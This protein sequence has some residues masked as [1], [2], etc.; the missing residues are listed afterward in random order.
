VAGPGVPIDPS[1]GPI[2]A[3][4]FDMDGLLID[5]EPLW[6]RVE[7]TI[8]ER[9]GVPLTE[10]RCVE[11]RGMVVS[12][13]TRHWYELD[14]WTGPSPEA[15]AEEIVEAMA[16]ELATGVVLKAGAVAALSSCRAHGLRLAIAS[17]SPARLI[18]VVVEAS[19]L[20]G[21]FSVLHS[22][23]EEKV[24]KPDPAVFLTTARHLGVA[25]GRCV[26]FEDSPAGVRAAIDA[27][28][29]CVA[30]PEDDGGRTPADRVVFSSADAVLHSL[31]EVND[32]LWARLS[33]GGS[34]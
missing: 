28:M 22:G 21:W 4:I 9:L 20:V 24:G 17:S 3:A 34:V 1:V 32:E 5:S 26:V 16:T 7:M 10:E 31:E 25:A 11:T 33:G 13:V 23:Q 8:F 15:V 30:V 12:E 19:G 27:G 29:R 18:E 2:G 14:P 6:R